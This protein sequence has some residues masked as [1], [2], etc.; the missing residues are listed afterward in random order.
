LNSPKIKKLRLSLPEKLLTMDI[1]VNVTFDLSQR[2]YILLTAALANMPNTAGE[3]AATTDKAATGAPA[4]S[5]AEASGAGK[6][7]REKAQAPIKE[8]PKATSPGVNLSA[9]TENTADQSAA[10]PAAG[11]NGNGQALDLETIRVK[12]VA[13]RDAGKKSDTAKLMKDKY[14]IQKLSDLP[15]DQYTAFYADLNGIK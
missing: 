8:M 13:L 9:S 3:S 6:K 1:N 5:T 15:T 14:G 7:P 2:V 10:D 12:V 4:A 11:A